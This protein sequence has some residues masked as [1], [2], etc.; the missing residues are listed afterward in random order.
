MILKVCCKILV[1]F[2]LVQNLEILDLA[3][4]K[5]EKVNIAITCCQYVDINQTLSNRSK[6]EIEQVWT[7]SVNENSGLIKSD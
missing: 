1:S 2:S 5:V 6:I 3:M 7:N 4:V